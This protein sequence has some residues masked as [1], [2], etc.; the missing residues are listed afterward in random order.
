MMRALPQRLR[1]RT[2]LIVLIAVLVVVAAGVAL[3]VSRSSPG[4]R[5]VNAF[6]A[7][8]PEPDGARVDLDTTLYVPEH[9][10]APAVLLA[11]GFGGD[12]TGLAGTAKTLAEHG[13]VVLAYTAR[14]FGN[15]GGLIHFDSPDF[16]VRDA[17]LLVDHLQSLPQVDKS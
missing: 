8:T 10:P 3:A 7:G 12:K 9:T 4:Y 15:S 5:T 11:Q 1:S 13:Y 16:E 6:V 2:F 17:Q 14:G